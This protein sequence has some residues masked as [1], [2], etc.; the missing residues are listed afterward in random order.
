MAVHA[1]PDPE[2]VKRRSGAVHALPDLEQV[3]EEVSWPFTHCQILNKS[4]RR[5]DDRSYTLPCRSGTNQKEVQVAFHLLY[6]TL[7]KS[8]RR[9]GG[10][11]RTAG[12]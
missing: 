6:Q 4:K 11:S 3:K 2:Q 9:S 10:R 7:N 8:E 1:L 12:S 5:S